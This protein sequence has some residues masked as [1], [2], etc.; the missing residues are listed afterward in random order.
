MSLLFG[1][2]GIPLSTEPRDTIRGIERVRELGLDAMEL[3][4][5]QSVNVSEQKAPEVKAAAKKHGVTLSCHAPYYVNLNAVEEDK[6]EASIQRIL[7][8]ARRLDQCGG[9]SV[10]FHPG[11]YLKDTPQKTYENIR[12]TLKNIS[13]AATD[14]GL[15]VTLRP[16]TTGKAKQFGSL[17]EL[18]QI[19][20]EFDNVLPCVDFSHLHARSG[21]KFNTEQEWEAVVSAVKDALGSRALS[22]FHAHLSG[23]AYGDK[24]EKNHL[25]LD[26]SDM[27]YPILLKIL[28][29][30][31]I[32]GVVVCESP[33][34]EG[35]ALLL[36]RTYE[37]L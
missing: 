3:E 30:H 5:V 23:I 26:E 4:F 22:S 29:T 7:L 34:I 14:E 19:S 36:K 32:S 31:N 18:L 33:N 37:K 20:A 9:G 16:E 21:G 13:A 12:N 2:A 27:Q 35:D 15:N 1:T 25:L 8:S 11:F 24:G 10:V 17:T 28:K 6:K